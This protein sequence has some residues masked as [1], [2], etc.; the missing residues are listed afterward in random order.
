MSESERQWLVAVLVSLLVAIRIVS[1]LVAG[2]MFRDQSDGVAREGGVWL[3]AG[4]R[5]VFLLG[6]LGGLLL[7]LVEP[8]WMPWQLDLPP[9][10]H[11]AG[12]VLAELGLVLLVWVQIS[13]GVHFSGTLHL[14]D[15][16]QL[17][18]HGPYARVRHPMYSA[19]LLIFFGLTLLTGNALIGAVLLGSQV[20]VLGWRL[21]KEEQALAE[22][23]GSSWQTYHA[24][25]GALTPW[26]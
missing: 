6:G 9:V 2:G 16:H 1:H 13:L 10:A 3:A 17:V 19:F 24:Q 7:W 23:F 4:L 12:L 8:S 20:W 21:P 15:D 11:L 14:R 5:L 25:T 26:F 18:R 22:R